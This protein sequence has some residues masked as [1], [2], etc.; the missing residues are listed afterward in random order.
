METFGAGMHT[1]RGCQ[2]SWSKDDYL[3]D[4]YCRFCILKHDGD[5]AAIIAFELLRTKLLNSCEG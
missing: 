1:C 4:G 2:N 3:Q 5:F